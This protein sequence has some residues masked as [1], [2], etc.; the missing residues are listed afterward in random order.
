MILVHVAVIKNIK[1]AV[2]IN[3]L[4]DINCNSVYVFCIKVYMYRGEFMNILILPGYA[5]K[6]WI[7]SKV[8][9]QLNSK[10]IVTTV[11]WPT[12]LT[13]NFN[14]IGDFSNWLSNE[15]KLSEYDVVIGHSMG[16]TIAL[17]LAALVEYFQKVILVD[18]FLVAPESFFQNFTYAETPKSVTKSLFDMMQSEKI[19]YSKK[20]GHG[21]KFYNVFDTLRSIRADIYIMYG[22]RGCNDFDVFRDNLNWNTYLNSRLKVYSIKNACHFPMLESIDDTVIKLEEILNKS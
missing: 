19:H 7:W 1:S 15:Y 3:N 12:T 8:I 20:I 5:C 2:L 16:G 11:D 21:M 17:D 4:D 6:S 13:K 22:N 9:N 10:Y 18:T 14:E